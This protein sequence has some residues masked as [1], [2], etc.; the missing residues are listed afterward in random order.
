LKSWISIAAS[1]F[2]FLT[3]PGNFQITPE[4][5]SLAMLPEIMAL[6]VVAAA[7]VAGAAAV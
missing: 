3:R 4:R 2:L 1:Y 6:V 5:V 7:V